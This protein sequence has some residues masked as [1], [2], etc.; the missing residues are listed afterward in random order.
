MGRRSEENVQGFAPIQV[1]E[2]PLVA[3]TLEGPVN[4]IVELKLEDPLLARFDFNEE[5][6]PGVN[7][8]NP[9]TYDAT[10]TGTS[11]TEGVYSSNTTLIQSD[12]SGANI[13]PY[14]HEATLSNVSL[15]Y[16]S[17]YSFDTDTAYVSFANSDSISAQAYTNM[18][19]EV[20]FRWDGTSP[21]TGD[22]VLISKWN[23][24]GNN[25]FLL[26]LNGSAQL[27]TS[28][29]N[30]ALLETITEPIVADTDYHF[31]ITKEGTSFKCFLNG[32]LRWTATHTPTVTGNENWILGQNGFELGTGTRGFKGEMWDFRLSSDVVY[33]E[34]GRTSVR[35]S[36]AGSNGA[37]VVA[38]DD[39]GFGSDSLTN[40]GNVVHSTA[41][42]LPGRSSSMYFNGSA[43]ISHNGIAFEQG[44]NEWQ[45][46]G[47]AHP[48]VVGGGTARNMFGVYANAADWIMGRVDGSGNWHFSVA[49]GGSP[50]FTHTKSSSVQANKWHHFCMS[51]KGGVWRTFIDGQLI[52]E[53]YYVFN[54]TTTT[55]HIGSYGTSSGYWVGFLQDIEVSTKDVVR[56]PFSPSTDQPTLLKDF[57]DFTL[58]TSVGGE[59]GLA[60]KF[61]GVDDDILVSDDLN[62]ATMT[63]GTWAAWVKLDNLTNQGAIFG[64]WDSNG[65]QRSWMVQVSSSLNKNFRFM[66]SSDGVDQLEQYSSST[67]DLLWHHV[68]LSK[69]SSDEWRLYIDG[70]LVSTST[71]SI[72]TSTTADRTY[73]ASLNNGA[74]HLE[75]TL[76]DVRVYKR[77]LTQEEVR[78][79]YRPGL[80]EASSDPAASYKFDESAEDIVT[81]PILNMDTTYDTVSVPTVDYSVDTEISGGNLVINGSVNSALGANPPSQ[82]TGPYGANNGLTFD[83][84]NDQHVFADGDM[85]KPS[86]NFEAFTI[87]IWINPDSAATTE[88]MVGKVEGGGWVDIDFHLS[89]HSS[90]GLYIQANNN[91]SNGG[92]SWVTKP[93]LTSGEWQHIAV[94]K[95]EGNGAPVTVYRNGNLVDFNSSTS[96]WQWHV[97]S[98]TPWSLGYNSYFDFYTGDLAELYI[99]GQAL[100]QDQI[101]GLMTGGASVLRTNETRD[102]DIILLPSDSSIP[103]QTT[104]KDNVTQNALAFDGVSD[105]LALPSGVLPSGNSAR[106]ISFWMNHNVA[107]TTRTYVLSYGDNVADGAF[108]IEI[109]GY[110]T[111]HHYE[112]FV[113]TASNNGVYTTNDAASSIYQEWAHV[114]ITSGGD[115][116]STKIYINGVAQPTALTGVNTPFAT[117][118][119]NQVVGTREWFA[120]SEFFDG[121]IEDIKVFDSALT[122]E[123]VSYLYS[124]GTAKRLGRFLEDTSGNNHGE[125]QGD[126]EVFQPYTIYDGSTHIVFDDADLKVAELTIELDFY[127]DN[128]SSQQ[129]MID[130]RDSGATTGI[131]FYNNNGNSQIYITGTG[132]S[133]TS[134]GAAVNGQWHRAKLE[135]GPSNVTVTIDDGTPTVVSGTIVT[136]TGDFRIGTQRNIQDFLSGGIRNLL[137]KDGE[138]VLLDLKKGSPE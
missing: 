114:V 135:I 61:D 137:V 49:L 127:L 58:P 84:A 72:H 12:S 121:S 48:T 85:W 115:H 2:T 95:E 120:T 80:K 75:A 29:D 96:P 126:L 87:A 60:R 28:F 132:I 45:I 74:L 118:D 107:D 52:G 62:M 124:E 122:N 90:G 46:S 117:V 99:T 69:D 136:P 27:E 9:G 20:K 51:Y 18:C 125:I 131:A 40:T 104:G 123:E 133:T 5:S 67:F 4:E 23:S 66:L 108:D 111:A 97:A 94:V 71:Q 43:R 101:R 100:T 57:T 128:N 79:L 39:D 25:S 38:S 65:N 77:V 54:F 113:Y 17:R 56:Y 98:T 130:N 134:V 1:V 33:E 7:S 138:T 55:N 63:E 34:S 106:T 36:S 92:F 91:G 68:A 13:S 50:Q 70:E 89:K 82:T 47:W 22:G 35:L 6:A 73:V 102:N 76:D 15:N 31:V 109:N 88:H 11:T 81:N 16:L 110:L 129:F 44:M 30:A 41:K 59:F 64:N 37:S 10:L 8:H 93:L 14:D 24:V 26:Q 53:D 21:T 105:K 86:A 78:H 103:T 3:T 112:F 42:T 116:N 119:A 83:G 19:I 32:V